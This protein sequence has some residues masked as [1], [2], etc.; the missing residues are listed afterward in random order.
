MNLSIKD[1]VAS[2]LA[3]ISIGFSYLM[4]TGY[5]FPLITNYRWAT[6]VLLVVGIAMCA[7]SGWDPSGAKS[8]WITLS[9]VLG[10]LAIILIIA[11]IVTGA[12]TI[13]MLLAGTIVVLWLL[14]T[15]HHMFGS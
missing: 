7:L 5:K 9:S 2:V 15:V 12:K 14:T 11:G 6:A 10:A 4:V 1:L 13:F 3:I 8:W